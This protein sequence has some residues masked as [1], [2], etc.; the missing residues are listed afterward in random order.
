MPGAFRV[1]V[2]KIDKGFAHVGL[3]FFSREVDSKE[4]N[5][6]AVSSLCWEAKNHG[7]RLGS[8]GGGSGACSSAVAR[9]G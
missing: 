7:A 6:T 5:K 1:A 3:L 8:R 4:G 9:S 2:D